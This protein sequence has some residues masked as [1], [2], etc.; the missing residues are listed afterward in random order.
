M[1]VRNRKVKSSRTGKY[2]RPYQ[3]R[4][5]KKGNEKIIAHVR[6]KERKL[7]EK[8]LNSEHKIRQS[9]KK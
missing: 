9:N 7:G 3:F 2:S 4:K 1:F 8:Q 5:K 6:G